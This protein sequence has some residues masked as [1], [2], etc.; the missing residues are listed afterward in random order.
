[1]SLTEDDI[2]KIA[3]AL[4]EKLMKQQESYE[5]ENNTYIISDE[6]GNSKHV[7]ELEYLHIELMKLEELLDTYV[8]E[9]EYE[10]ANMIKNKIRMIRTKIQKL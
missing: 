2:N 1:M 9:E 7:D 5:K 4:F 6:F 10:K 3:E 8:K